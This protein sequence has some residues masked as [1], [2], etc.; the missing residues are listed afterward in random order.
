MSEGMKNLN[1]EEMESVAGGAA[2]AGSIHDKTTLVT[3]IVSGL[4]A[5]KALVMYRNPGSGEMSIR[6]HNG[7]PIQ[8]QPKSVTGAYILAYQL[9]PGGNKDGTPGKWGYV[10]K[11]YV[12]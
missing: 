7:D 12:M 10:E 8:V 5:G 6:Y 4:P 11:K 3:K 1:L 9:I 2:K